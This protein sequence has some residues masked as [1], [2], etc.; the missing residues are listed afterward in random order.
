MFRAWEQH[1]KRM[2]QRV[3]QAQGITQDEPSTR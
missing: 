3:A 2:A 1:K